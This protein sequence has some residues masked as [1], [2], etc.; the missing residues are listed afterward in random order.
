MPPKNSPAPVELPPM[1]DGLELAQ[2]PDV[3]ALPAPDQEFMDSV[4]DVVGHVYIP[5]N[6]P[7]DEAGLLALDSTVDRLLGQLRQVDKEAARDLRLIKE[8]Q[9]E[10]D[11]YK[12]T[13]AAVHQ[14]RADWL[15]QQ[16][17][18][19]ARAMPYVGRQSRVLPNGSVGY[20]KGQ[21]KVEIKDEE[22]A[23]RWAEQHEVPVQVK[24]TVY[25]ND[26]KAYAKQH[27]GVLPEG[28]GAIVVPA[29][30][31]VYY[32]RLPKAPASAGAAQAADTT[33]QE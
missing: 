22:V 15:E 10:L 21:D 1:P 11:D 6:A 2:H 30:E 19:L 23:V 20:T 3:V 12:A 7:H 32:V 8:R 33:D 26:L 4:F 24:K 28:S 18:V 5:A 9:R 14:K 29:P 27:G 17:L 13:R 16:A 31:K 25:L